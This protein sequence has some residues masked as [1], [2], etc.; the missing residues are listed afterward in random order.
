M[1]SDQQSFEIGHPEVYKNKILFS[2]HSFFSQLQRTFTALNLDEFEELIH[3]DDKA[4]FNAFIERLWLTGEPYECSLRYL[5]ICGAFIPLH[6]RTEIVSD[7]NEVSVIAI[8]D[9]ESEKNKHET[10]LEIAMNAAGLEFWETNILTGE[11]TRK[12]IK[13]F[14]DLGYSE[15]ESL[16]NTADFTSFVHPEDLLGLLAAIDDHYNKKTDE[17][18]CEFRVK[19]KSDEWE[20]VSNYGR[21]IPTD[22]EWGECFTGV[23]VNINDKKTMEG[24]TRKAEKMAL[25][26]D[27]VGGVAHNFNNILAVIIGNLFLAKVNSSSLEIH[28]YLKEIETSSDEASSMV[29]QLLNFIH[30]SIEKKRPVLIMSLLREATQIAQLSFSKDIELFTDFT[31]EALRVNCNAEEI[32]NCLIHIILNAKD[33]LE[34]ISS[35]KIYVKYKRQP[36]NKC[37]RSVDCD[38][39]TT[40]KVHLQV[41]D[42]GCGISKKDLTHIY[43][44]FFT[45]KE[46]GKSKGLGLSMVKGVVESHDGII[47]ISSKKGE[48]TKATICLP[49]VN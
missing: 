9:I 18:R 33:A 12:A 31:D 35:K 4:I 30:Y 17:Y 27:L 3:P 37:N 41:E 44:P 29:K 21:I 25:M 11:I 10:K 48:G 5:K 38:V 45:T 23:S 47:H 34:N 22:G 36:R 26:R 1:K 2:D 16:A 6:L 24:V 13:I 46:A 7:K 32:K 49:L 39:C 20:W 14:E 19:T 42:T 40:D 8:T 28:G 43:D 15:E